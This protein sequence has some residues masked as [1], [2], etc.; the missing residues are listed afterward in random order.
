MKRRE[1]MIGGMAASGLARPALA[2]GNA[3]V[4]RFVPQA[5]VT[6]LDGIANTQLVVRNV[7][8]LVFDTLYGT[9]A[10]IA[11]RPQM[12]EGHELSEDQ[13]K[14]TFTLRPGL[15]FHDGE[16]VLARDA[17]AS[18]RRWMARDTMGQMIRARLDAIEAID[19]RRFRLRLKRPFS[20]LLYAFGKSGSPMLLIMPERIANLDPSR[21]VAEFIGSGPMRFRADEW[22]TGSRAVFERFAGYQPREEP[23]SWLAGGKRMLVDR[24]EWLT[25]PDPSTAASALQK[26]EVDWWENPINDL[27]PL[28]GRNR[29]IQVEIADPL[30]N[31][32]AFAMNH[33]QPPFN[34]RRVRQ[35]LQIA[36]DQED[37]MQAVC[38]SDTRLWRTLP[39]FFTPG[40]PF[41]TEA[42]AERLKG[43]REPGRAKALIEAAGFGGHRVVLLSASD[44]PAVRAQCEVTAD[45]LRRLGFN[46]DYQSMD[47]GTLA[48]RR[49]NKGPIDQG[50]WNLFCTWSAGAG[51]INPAGY[52]PLDASGPTAWFGWPKSDE[53]QASI[54]AWF[55][56]TGEEAERQAMVEV[57]RRSM[58]FVTYI[59]TGFF[60]NSTAWRRDVRGI[61]KAPFPVFW[62]V[63][64]G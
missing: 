1:L 60:L 8:L 45:L 42:G 58:D 20:K 9:D 31:I 7:G 36:I 61:V 54:D 62:G 3:R 15:R 26:G 25:M 27:L 11:V 21:P 43:P 53:V 41:Y 44:V 19:D 55:D 10:E 5:D 23:A 17:V 22:R 32:G 47:W 59:P 33:L 28:L 18:I 40:T 48:S 14:W 37:Y 12:C 56:A 64:K 29:D 2:Q 30:G 24:I 63:S 13:K 46:V 49:L 34:D 16:P 38:G 4:L 39:S 52:K 6:T 50:G 35:A 51:C 57:S